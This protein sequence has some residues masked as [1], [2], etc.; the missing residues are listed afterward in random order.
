[1]ANVVIESQGHDF[2]LTPT[3]KIH[4]HSRQV[5][6]I[7][8]NPD[9]EEYDDGAVCIYS[10]IDNEKAK[11]RAENL[12]VIIELRSEEHE[13]IIIPYLQEA[14]HID[15][16]ILNLRESLETEKILRKLEN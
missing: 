5:F 1:M 14:G 11:T 2:I 10:N 9:Y 8:T 15:I 7:E 4:S 3:T 12:N 16:T 6:K 13:E